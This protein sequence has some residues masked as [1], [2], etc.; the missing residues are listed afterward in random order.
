MP[1][2]SLR[3]GRTQPFQFCRGWTHSQ[4]NLSTPFIP[5]QVFPKLFLVSHCESLVP[6]DHHQPLFFGENF[7]PTPTIVYLKGGNLRGW[8]LDWA[9]SAA[10]G[11][12]NLV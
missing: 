6:Y 10:A 5:F 7:S 9:E 3:F 12:T 8:S 11:G 1:D 4:E 2:I